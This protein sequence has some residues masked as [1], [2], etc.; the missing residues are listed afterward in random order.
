MDDPPPTISVT[1]AIALP[2]AQCKTTPIQHKSH[3]GLQTTC[4]SGTSPFV[5]PCG[6][7]GWEQCSANHFSIDVETM[8]IRV[9][10]AQPPQQLANVSDAHCP[11]A[12]GMPGSVRLRNHAAWSYAKA[13]LLFF[14][15]MLI[16]WIPSSANRMYS[17]I[18]RNQVSI[19]LQY[20]SAFVLPLQGLWNAIIYAVTSHSACKSL[21]Y[22]VRAS[23]WPKLREL[24]YG[25]RPQC[26]QPVSP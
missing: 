1:Q 6:I 17:I 22:D 19:A 26:T 9:N 16:T 14:L 24:I 11:H 18:H 3:R 4:V 20:M 10:L 15:A 21:F 25:M 13:S 7:L 8:T 5:L 23:S 2:R 12:P